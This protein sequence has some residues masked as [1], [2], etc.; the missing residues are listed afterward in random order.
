MAEDNTE[1]LRQ[2]YERLAAKVQKT[3]PNTPERYDAME[4]KR[5]AFAE[6]HAAEEGKQKV[7]QA[8]GNVEQ[9]KAA[10]DAAAKEAADAKA[11][12]AEVQRNA[13]RAATHSPGSTAPRDKK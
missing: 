9:K 4:A 3:A 11:A 1:S 5:E 10:A 13:A 6:L 8:V 2:K 12:A 7:D